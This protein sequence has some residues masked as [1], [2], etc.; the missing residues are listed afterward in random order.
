MGL[1]GDPQISLSFQVLDLETLTWIPCLN[2]TFFLILQMYRHTS[3]K[4]SN[5]CGWRLSHCHW[6]RGLFVWRS[7]QVRFYDVI[8]TCFF[9]QRRSCSSCK[10]PF[11]LRRQKHW[12]WNRSNYQRHS[13][14]WCYC[15]NRRWSSRVS[16][17]YSHSRY[18]PCLEIQKTIKTRTTTYFRTIQT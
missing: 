16:G 12:S 5:S 3:R 14:C 2:I 4:Y 8:M 13:S 11:S 7:H 6:W 15:R 1:I 17:N 10:Q 9:P 18:F